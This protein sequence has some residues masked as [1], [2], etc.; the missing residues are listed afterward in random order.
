MN[1]SSSHNQT[2][3]CLVCHGTGNKE[4]FVCRGSGKQSETKTE[5]CTYCNG[6]G[7]GSLEIGS[8]KCFWCG[9]KGSSEVT[10][11]IECFLCDGIGYVSCASC[12]GNGFLESLETALPEFTRTPLYDIK[13]TLTDVLSGPIVSTNKLKDLWS[14]ILELFGNT[15]RTLE[16]NVTEQRNKS[17]LVE[18]LT[19][20][21]RTELRRK[22]TSHFS[23]E[24]LQTLCTDLDIDHEKI[25]GTEK[26]SKARELI[27]YCERTGKVKDLLTEC[28][29]LRS[30]VTWP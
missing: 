7:F 15:E 1:L 21:T 25:P 29:K 26:E 23:L 8:K 28:C 10:K 24:E 27:A 16:N 2:V 13:P 4:C 12:N 3:R 20:E 30:H 11:Q 5:E 17:N 6:V 22:L 14:R 9:G 18:S 19:K